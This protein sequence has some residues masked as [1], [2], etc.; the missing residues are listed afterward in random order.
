MKK[1]LELK[2][3]NVKSFITGEDVNQVKGGASCACSLPTQ[4][5]CVYTCK[6]NNWC[7]TD[8]C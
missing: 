6:S 2:D 5:I 4:Q 3:L 7:P 8:N 1:A